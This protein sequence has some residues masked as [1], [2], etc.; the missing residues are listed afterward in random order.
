MVNTHWVYQQGHQGVSTLGCCL[1]TGWTFTT[2]S[3]GVQPCMWWHHVKECVKIQSSS[4]TCRCAYLGFSYPWALQCGSWKP[5]LL[6]QIIRGSVVVCCYIP[7]PAS[8][9]SLYLAVPALCHL[10]S[11]QEGWVWPNKLFWE[12]EKDHIHITW[13]TEHSCNCSILLLVTVSF[14]LCLIYKLNFVIKVCM[15]RKNHSIYGELGTMC[16]FRCFKHLFG[17]LNT[18]G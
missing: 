8:F 10:T 16:S 2:L 7:M 5:G 3:S 15:Y 11:S 13:I 17:V 1:D 18:R 6:L 4:L 12:R 9:T 14:L